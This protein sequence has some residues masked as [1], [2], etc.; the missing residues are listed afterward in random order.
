VLHSLA[1]STGLGKGQLPADE[2]QIACF[3][4]GWVV[5]LRLL[6][7]VDRLGGIPDG[8]TLFTQSG[9][10]DRESLVDFTSAACEVAK[11]EL[12]EEPP[13]LFMVEQLSL[14]AFA[15]VGRPHF[16]WISVWQLLGEFL[17]GVI[18]SD[19]FEVACVGI[20]VLRSLAARF[21]P[22]R[23]LSD[24]H[25][26]ACFMRTF[27]D[28]FESQSS[29]LI[30]EYLLDS[31]NR[32]VRSNGADLKDGW[33]FKLWQLRSLSLRYKGPRLMC[34]GRLSSQILITSG[35]TWRKSQRSWQPLSP[36][37]S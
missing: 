21:L 19:N 20:N 25:F 26:Q 24:F 35:H 27:L 32:I 37:R 18:A 14:I 36:K 29:V 3:K 33:R 22:D 23:S 12:A 11:A 13:R 28:G 8:A 6:S 15:N 17:H 4:L 2:R 31:L 34:C 7:A 30:K 1:G 9:T 16:I 10:F 5:V